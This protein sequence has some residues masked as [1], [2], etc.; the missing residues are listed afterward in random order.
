LE[1]VLV[2]LDQEQILYAQ[3]VCR[4]WGE[5]IRSSLPL[6]R[7]LYLSPTTKIDEQIPVD[8]AWLKSRFPEFGMYLLQGNPK[9]RPKFIKALGASD[10]DRLGESFFAEPDASWRNMLLTQP[11]IK[12]VVVFSKIEETH[13][14]GATI[15]NRKSRPGLEGRDRQPSSPS[16]EEMMKASV[17]IRNGK[18]VT[19][20]MIVDAGVEARRR[21]SL[22]ARK[23]MT[24]RK[25]SGYVSLEDLQIDNIEVS[26]VE[27]SD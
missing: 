8:N 6:R 26:V 20:G 23:R 4:H 14:S 19:M 7:K 1:L 16:I 13:G 21:G 15:S 25:D 18:G 27:V 11:P 3:R 17:T 5:I 12:E 24:D 2:H 22:A 9:W 10:F